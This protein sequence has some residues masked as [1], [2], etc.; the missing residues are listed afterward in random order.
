MDPL[1][2]MYRKLLR[3]T[4]IV[5]MDE[6]GNGKRDE[7]DCACQRRSAAQARHHP[8]PRASFNKYSG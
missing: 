7:V 2:V 5:L 8:I 4:R 1:T 3:Y 6:R